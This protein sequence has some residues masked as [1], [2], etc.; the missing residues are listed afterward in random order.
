MLELRSSSRRSLRALLSTLLLGLFATLTL[1]WRVAQKRFL[2]SR[3]CK[4]KA[5]LGGN[6]I[7]D[8]L[9]SRMTEQFMAQFS[10]TV[11][12]KVRE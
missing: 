7:N 6:M 10:N 12:T 3:G 4:G 1:T 8:D 5:C 11:S 9:D 2:V